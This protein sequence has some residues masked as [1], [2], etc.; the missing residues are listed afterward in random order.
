MAP[1]ARH[2]TGSA[3]TPSSARSTAT[4]EY[5]VDENGQ[6]YKLGQPTLHHAPAAG[7]HGIGRTQS[8][9]ST[10]STTTDL[11][12]DNLRKLVNVQ[13][14]G[15]STGRFDASTIKPKMSASLAPTAQGPEQN[16][17]R[18]HSAASFAP[19]SR[20]GHGP[21]AVDMSL[22][23]H[24]PATAAS[25][26]LTT[27]RQ[28]TRAQ[29]DHERRY[30]AI[31][32]SALSSG[33]GS[34]RTA[35]TARRDDDTCDPYKCSGMDGNCGHGRYKTTEVQLWRNDKLVETATAHTPTEVFR[36]AGAMAGVDPQTLPAPSEDSP[37]R[38]GSWGSKWNALR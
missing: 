2:H 17:S 8:V 3:Y 33:G 23:A 38:T 24:R 14:E 6:T 22:S 29:W 32:P 21:E 9:R 12:A 11:T 27:G 7:Q 31:D 20:P 30:F 18:P 25:S 35:T 5:G 36:V 19:A 34:T 13:P 1:S 16:F 10:A 26:H 4:T 28:L 37:Y 15:A